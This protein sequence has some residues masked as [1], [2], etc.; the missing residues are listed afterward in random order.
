MRARWRKTRAILKEGLEAALRADPKVLEHC[1]PR[2]GAGLIVRGLVLE[3]GKGRTTSLKTLMSLIDWEPENGEADLAAIPD[4][5]QWDWNE[6]GIWETLPEPAPEPGAAAPEEG[7]AKKELRRRIT[8]LMEA[9]DYERV[10]RIMEAA[11]SG[12][13][14]GPDGAGAPSTA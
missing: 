1:V 4:E 6:E 3:A 14:D 12:N 8:R 10:A 13:Y 2:T 7:P 9:G 11:V 5:T